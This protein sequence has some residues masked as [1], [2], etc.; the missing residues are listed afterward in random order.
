MPT[1]PLPEN[2]KTAK[3]SLRT[4]LLRAAHRGDGQLTV[5]QA[6]ME[7]GE[8]FAKVERGLRKMVTAGHIDVD[9]EPDSG[10]IVYLFP[11]LVGRPAAPPPE[12][13][14]PQLRGADGDAPG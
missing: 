7:T 2:E 12:I 1:A 11:E 14:N 4:R 10:V 6:V 5:T 3:E 9:N 13:S 8:S